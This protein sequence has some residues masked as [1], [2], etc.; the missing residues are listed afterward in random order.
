MKRTHWKPIPDRWEG[1]RAPTGLSGGRGSVILGVVLLTL[2]LAGTLE[3][4]AAQEERQ[5][6]DCCLLLLVPVGA[7]SSAMGGAITARMGPDAVFRNPA[8]LAGLNGATFL[9]H[10]SD[11]S[12]VDVNALSLVFGTP[13]GT[14]GLSYQLFDKGA[15]TTTD[16]TGQPTGEIT[17]RDHLLVA[18]YGLGVGAGMAVGASYKFF[19]ER[20]DCRGLCGGAERVTT[21]HSVDLGYRFSPA[22]HPALQLGV[23]AVNVPVGSSG[24]DGSYRFP[25]RVHAGVAYDVLSPFGADEA[26]GLRLALDLQDELHDLGSIVPSVGLELDMQEALFLRAGY[27]LG[28]GLAS[29]AAIGVELRY[30][31]FDIGVSRSFVNSGFEEGE[32]FQVTFGVHF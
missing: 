3:P 18:S 22:R 31:R 29:G 19:Q 14:G 16:G 10:H 15:Q 32:P 27:T 25:S 2:V 12:L 28:E 7:R 1:L 20:I 21:F 24:G 5:E 30:D 8:G 26:M 13:V 9:V 11:R 6:D 4:V 23:A 17:Y